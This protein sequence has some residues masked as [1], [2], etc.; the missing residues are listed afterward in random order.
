VRVPGLPTSRTIARTETIGIV[1]LVLIIL[2]VILVR[3]GG[4]ILWSA[5]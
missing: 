5:R 4:V 1:I 2:L 3:W